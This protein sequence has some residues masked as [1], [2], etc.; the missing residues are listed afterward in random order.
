MQLSLILLVYQLNILLKVVKWRKLRMFNA[1]FFI[2]K[3]T[4]SILLKAC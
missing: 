4:F 2:T 1:Q 3:A